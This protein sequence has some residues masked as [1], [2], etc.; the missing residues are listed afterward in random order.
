MSLKYSVWN[1]ITAELTPDGVVQSMN[2]SV[3]VIDASGLHLDEKSRHLAGIYHC[4][5]LDDLL[6]GPNRQTQDLSMPG[7]HWPQRRVLLNGRS[8]R[9]SA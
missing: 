1:C 2:L 6:E 7:S 4:G 9:G 5:I 3:N 8:V